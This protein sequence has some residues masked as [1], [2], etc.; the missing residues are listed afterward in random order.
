MVLGGGCSSALGP[1]P[2]LQADFAQERQGAVTHWPAQG[3]R[4]C[5]PAS[6]GGAL[7]QKDKW[8]RCSL[9]C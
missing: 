4:E 6:T 5:L 9:L 3:T 1:L 2:P 7:F 8:V